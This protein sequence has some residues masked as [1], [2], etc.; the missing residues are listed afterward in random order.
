MMI[1]KEP[2]LKGQSYLLRILTYNTSAKL[3]MH[4]L[5]CFGEKSKLT[6]DSIFFLFLFG[7]DCFMIKFFKMD[8]P[9]LTNKRTYILERIVQFFVHSDVV[10]Y[11]KYVKNMS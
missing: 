7:M 9:R 11:A 1:P 5:L 2:D 6:S 8:M 3:I 4:I 10:T